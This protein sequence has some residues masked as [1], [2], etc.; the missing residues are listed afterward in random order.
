M[1]FAALVAAFVIT[2]PPYEWP[3]ARTG[4]GVW[5]KTLAM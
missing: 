4:P 3:T 2:A 5:L 1:T